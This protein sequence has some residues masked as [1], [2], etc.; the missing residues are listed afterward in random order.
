VEGKCKWEVQ[1]GSANE[2]VWGGRKVVVG[3][4]WGVGGIWEVSGRWKG[5]ANGKCK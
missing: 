3:V 4:R 1:M 5:S 2:K